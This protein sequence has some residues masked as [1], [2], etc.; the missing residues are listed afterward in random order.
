MNTFNLRQILNEIVKDDI[1]KC[2]APTQDVAL[3]TANRDRAI[4]ADFIRYGPLNVEEPGDYW[5]I[6]AE[7]WNTT[8]EAAKKSKCSN[9]VAF[10]VSPRMVDKC[11]LNAI[12]LDHVI[13][14]QQVV[15]LVK[16]KYLM[17]GKKE[18]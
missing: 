18:T 7:K 5:E 14:G 15:Q 11:I 13:L 8:V 2:P 16:M 4:E 12:Q 10:D 17:I 1:K 9:C 6:T 3:N